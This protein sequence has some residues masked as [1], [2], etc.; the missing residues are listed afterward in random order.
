MPKEGSEDEMREEREG[1]WRTRRAELGLDESS[2]LAVEHVFDPFVDA[3]VSSVGR[4]GEGGEGMVSAELSRKKQEHRNDSRKARP[5]TRPHLQQVRNNPFV[6][7]PHSLCP[8]ELHD[9][10]PSG[11]VAIAHGPQASDL[12]PSSEDV[13]WVGEL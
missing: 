8:H 11:I 2:W 1:G 12:H 6:Q 10:F 5:N 9:R 3:V 13:E 4:E 7:T